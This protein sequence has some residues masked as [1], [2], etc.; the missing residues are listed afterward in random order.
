VK[1]QVYLIQLGY[2]IGNDNLKQTFLEFYKDWKFKHPSP[3]DFRRTAEKVSGLNLKWYENL[4]VNTTRTIDYAIS[5]VSSNSIEL[6]NL[7]NFPMPID[8][9]VEYADG[10]KKLFYIPNL[11]LRGEKPAE[12][13]DLY[14]GTKRTVLKPWIWTNPDYS[15]KISK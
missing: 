7:S 12:E 11:E 4:F 13:F 2:I 14:K 15:V 6:K 10:T 8:L 9:L 1:G 3:V 5:N